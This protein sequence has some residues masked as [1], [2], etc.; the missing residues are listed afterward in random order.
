MRV[1]EALNHIA[2]D[3]I[4]WLQ[5][6]RRIAIHE[7]FQRI[8]KLP[9]VIEA[10]D[11]TNIPIKASKVLTYIT[12]MRAELIFFGVVFLINVVLYF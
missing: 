10:I 7:K 4:V 8:G 9:H 1:V 6:D 3:V 5:E 12:K 2:E 11:G